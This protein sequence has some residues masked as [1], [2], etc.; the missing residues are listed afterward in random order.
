MWIKE[1]GK[2]GPENRPAGRLMGWRRGRPAHPRGTV[3][4]LGPR[5]A[6]WRRTGGKRGSVEAVMTLESLHGCNSQKP[7][8][9][10]WQRC[11]L[12]LGL[13]SESPGAQMVCGD[14]AWRKLQCTHLLLGGVEN[15]SW[16]SLAQL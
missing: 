13:C 4:G 12:G 8:A 1:K 5:R 10:S 16:A 14:R 15:P 6:S 7:P 3:C 11:R 9:P 2:T